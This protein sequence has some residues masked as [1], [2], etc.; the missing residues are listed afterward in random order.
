MLTPGLRDDLELDVRGIT[1]LGDKNFLNGQHVRFGERELHLLREIEQRVGG[2][3]P[4][5]DGAEDR[6]RGVRGRGSFGGVRQD[7]KEGL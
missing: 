7:V 6:A 5:R 3:F 2:Q 4:D 1:A